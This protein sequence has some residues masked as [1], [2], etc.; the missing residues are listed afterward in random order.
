[1]GSKKAMLENGLGDILRT[2]IQ[3]SSRFVDLF[4]GSGIVSCYIAKSY[5]VPVISLDIQN[6][7]MILAKSVIERQ[8]SVNFKLLE[9]TWIDTTKIRIRNSKYWQT[10]SQIEEKHDDIVNYVRVSRNLCGS[11]VTTIGPIW[12]SYGGHYFSPK[13]SLIFDYLIK[14]LPHKEPFKT[15]SLAALIVAASKCVAS[16]GHTA[17]PF[18]PTKTAGKFILESWSK[19]PFICVYKALE[20]ICPQHARIKG[21]AIAGDAIEYAKRL[22]EADL[23]FVD[24]PY[25]GVQYSRFYHVL[26]TIANGGCGR[27][28]WTGRY[29]PIEERI[30]SRFCNKGQSRLA[31]ANLLENLSKTGC[32]V[33]FTYPDRECSNGLSGDFVKYV[34]RNWY[35]INEKKVFTNFSTLGGNNGN[36]DARQPS[37]ELILTLT[38]K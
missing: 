32:T 12:N 37:Y 38:P 35:R 13:Q 20:E 15:V 34:S 22:S 6:Y 25:S 16:P 26:E 18:Q 23:V 29:P 11:N 8:T 21:S 27:V 30:Q 19:D 9:R 24:P 4:S 10:A 7:S 14:Y 1:M 28:S 17:Q 5:S 33:I 3:S 2:N 31:L 36:R